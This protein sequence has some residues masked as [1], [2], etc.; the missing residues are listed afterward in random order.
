MSIFISVDIVNPFTVA[1][2]IPSGCVI[3]LVSNGPFKVTCF[4]SLYLNVGSLLISVLALDSID[5]K[6][7]LLIDFNVFLFHYV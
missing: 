5:E 2:I 1:V 3:I 6:N 7:F 4:N